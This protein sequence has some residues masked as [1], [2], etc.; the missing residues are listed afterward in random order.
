MNR[1]V[2]KFLFF[3]VPILAILLAWLG[4]KTVSTNPIGW[5]LIVVGVLFSIGIL[6]AF[7][8]KGKNLWEGS[9]LKEPILQERDDRSFWFVTLGM[10]F[11]FYLPPIEYLFLSFSISPSPGLISIG[12]GFIIIG[13]F[14]FGYARHV[15]RRWYSGHISVQ[16][17]HVLIQH[18]PYKF[19]R[20]PAYLG[21]LLMALGICSGYASLI[22]LIN[23]LFL[24][25]CL[26]LRIKVEEKI[27]V[28]HF[29][30][31]YLQYA[32]KTK[33]LIPLIW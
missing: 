3:F 22:G 32:R 19:V 27:L 16:A 31:L 24:I 8:L 1:H 2:E 33:K 11:A 10:I 29:G 13:S 6:I 25:Y 17:D 21:Y 5:F 28:D 9:D 26:H 14:M 4:F 7:L 23:I 18:G 15:L 30:E 12:L 20:H